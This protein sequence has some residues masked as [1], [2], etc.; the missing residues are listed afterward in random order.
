MSS[1]QA[2]VLLGTARATSV[3][4]AIFSALASTFGECVFISNNYYTKVIVFLFNRVSV[5][6]LNCLNVSTNKGAISL[7]CT[8]RSTSVSMMFFPY[9][10]LI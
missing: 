1:S 8:F 3:G 9:C 5:E 6:T 10:G 7:K 4:V 2:S